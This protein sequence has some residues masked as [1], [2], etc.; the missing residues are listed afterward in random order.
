MNKL[1]FRNKWYGWGWY[2]ATWQGWA[3]IGVYVILITA[4]SFTIDENSPTR[5]VVFTFILPVTLLT[6]TLIRICY[7]TGEKPKWQWGPPKNDSN[8]K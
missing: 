1:W 3:V 6:I 5:E 8:K 7:K 2:P 4:F